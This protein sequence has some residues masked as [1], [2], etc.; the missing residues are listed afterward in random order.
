MLMPYE[1]LIAP[2]SVESGRSTGRGGGPSPSTAWR[3]SARLRGRRS[4][5]LAIT[6]RT[7]GAEPL[8]T[9]TIRPPES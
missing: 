8:A 7:N 6:G 5:P 4:P 9:V 1:T 3:R 2:P